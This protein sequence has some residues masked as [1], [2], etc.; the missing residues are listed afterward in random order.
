M[1]GGVHIRLVHNRVEI[2]N[3]SPLHAMFNAVRDISNVLC[4]SLAIG[5]ALLFAYVL[6]IGWLNFAIEAICIH[7]RGYSRVSR[8]LILTTIC[9]RTYACYKVLWWQRERE[10]ERELLDD[11]VYEC[12]EN[13]V[14]Q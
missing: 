7:T 9:A 11:N 3:R 10:E 4:N 14:G 2:H 6:Y 1:D 13:I 12:A 8:Y 5:I